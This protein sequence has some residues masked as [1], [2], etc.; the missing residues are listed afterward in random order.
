[1]DIIV[2]SEV[3]SSRESDSGR[4]TVYRLRLP[5]NFIS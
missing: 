1:M 2:L 5:T 3:S 4:V